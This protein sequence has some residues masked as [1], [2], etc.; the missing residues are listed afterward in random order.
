MFGVFLVLVF[1]AVLIGVMVAAGVYAKGSNLPWAI[2]AG[3]FLRPLLQLVTREVQLFSHEVGGDWFHYSMLARDVSFVW[4]TE[5]FHYVTAEEVPDLGSTSLPSNLFALVLYVSD[6]ITFRFACT[7]LIAFSAA[8]TVI[9]LFSL[10]VEFG[11]P[12]GQAAFFALLFY[13]QPA[14]LFYTADMFKD[15]LVLCFI[16]GALG[17]ALRLS[18]RFSIIHAAVGVLC[19]FALWQVRFYLV[20]IASVTLLIGIMGVGAKQSWIRTV[21]AVGLLGLSVLFLGLYS[22]VFDTAAERMNETFVGGTAVD[23]IKGNAI[24][25]SAVAF[26]DGGNPFGAIHLK[27]LYT[28]FSPFPW[29][30]GSIGL[31]LGKLDAFIFYY[32]IY[33][34][35]RA[36]RTAD[37]QLVWMLGTFIVPCT[38]M[39]ATSMANVGLIVRQRLVIVAAMFILAAV[40]VP[41]PVEKLKSAKDLLL[42]RVREANRARFS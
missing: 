4:E 35:V 2:L 30:G 21:L 7:A 32:V 38:V 1:A 33:R 12:R 31:Q 5:G 23:T 24:G 29:S 15:G 8:L 28:L 25:G 16:V 42:E 11:A 22:T 39:Y 10:A 41:K 27:I 34:A 20:F 14:F 26:D 36:V 37:K 17:S 18:R 40:Y 9:N 19:L 13:F 6:D 3:Y